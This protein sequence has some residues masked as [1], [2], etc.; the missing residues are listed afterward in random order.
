MEA[1]SGH[2]PVMAVQ[3]ITHLPDTTLADL[4][5]TDTLQHASQYYAV[6][7]ISVLLTHLNTTL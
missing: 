3:F 2:C 4:Q 5:H 7:H 6:T 1:T